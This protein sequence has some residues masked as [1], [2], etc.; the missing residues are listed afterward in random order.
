VQDVFYPQDNPIYEW[1][2]MNDHPQKYPNTRIKPDEFEVVEW[3][4]N[5]YIIHL[6]QAFAS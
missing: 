5:P 4:I 3:G 1:S 6:C 2:A